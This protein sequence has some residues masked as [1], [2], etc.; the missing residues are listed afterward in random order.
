[1]DY[2]MGSIILW[3]GSRIPDGFFEC[4]GQQLATQEYAALFSLIGAIYGGDGK[5]TFA[6]PDLRCRVPV[7][8]GTS[9]TTGVNIKVGDKRGSESVT[10]TDANFIHSH[11]ATFASTETNV[12]IPVVGDNGN[13]NMPSATVNLAGGQFG[14]DPVNIYSNAA[15]TTNLK[16]IPVNVAGSVTVAAN[17]AGTTRTPVSV[18]TPQLGLTYL[19]C[20]EGIYPN[21]NY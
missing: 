1:M 11:G 17:A 16:P 10:L 6:L 19:I 12:S 13:T 3:S 20:W 21:F 15:A 14:R 2:M 18:V 9:P 5:T 7:G 4:N 8:R